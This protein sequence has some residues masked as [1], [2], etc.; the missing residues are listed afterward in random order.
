MNESLHER[1][2]KV[3]FYRNLKADVKREVDKLLNT[4][5]TNEE[6]RVQFEKI[7]VEKGYDVNNDDDCFIEA[8]N[9]MYQQER[10]RLYTKISTS[11]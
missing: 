3:E 1:L 2:S 4:E 5:F 8:L 7:D 11:G 6:V 9:Q 10:K